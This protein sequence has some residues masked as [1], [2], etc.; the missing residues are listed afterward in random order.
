MS[1]TTEDEIVYHYYKEF[2]TVR[3]KFQITSSDNTTLVKRV[4]INNIHFFA[5]KESI[6]FTKRFFDA[7]R[8]LAYK[9]F[10]MPECSD[11]NRKIDDVLKKI[12]SGDWYK[13]FPLIGQISL[14]LQ[15]II[16]DTGIMGKIIYIE[17]INTATRAMKNLAVCTV[18]SLIVHLIMFN[19]A[20]KP[21]DISML[22]VL[23]IGIAGSIATDYK[24]YMRL[25]NQVKLLKKYAKQREELLYRN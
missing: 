7:S 21:G 8:I 14:R 11:H 5:K 10:E 19:L 1:I 25:F 2:D 20:N 12:S 23:I 18:I 4:D 13:S 3:K 9:L 15:S 16:Y 17:I 6:P 24:N 22:F